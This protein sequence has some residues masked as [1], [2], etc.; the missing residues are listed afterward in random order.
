MDPTKQPGIEIV[1]VIVE[2]AEFEHRDDYLSVT[3]P[4]NVGPL[5]FT[6]K[7]QFAIAPSKTEG[8]VK[9]ELTTDRGQNPLYI[10]SAVVVGLV[11]I[12]EGAANMP[13]EQYA[14]VHGAGML[15]PFLRELVATLTGRGRFGPVWL[16]PV[17]FLA[18]AMAPPAAPS[19]EPPK[20]ATS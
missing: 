1:Q 8:A 5:P 10:V 2:R 15:F 4:P 14:A 13:L 6:L 11:R 19:T 16:P 9:L 18:G 12:T 20:P 17:N 7:T 3:P